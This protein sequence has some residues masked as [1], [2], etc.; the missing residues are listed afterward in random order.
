MYDNIVNYQAAYEA[1]EKDGSQKAYVY[2]TDI[3]GKDLDPFYSYSKK[4]DITGETSYYVVGPQVSDVFYNVDRATK[5]VVTT[6]TDKA[7]ISKKVATLLDEEGKDVVDENGAPVQYVKY[8]AL[9]I[10]TAENYKKY[11]LD[12]DDDDDTSSGLTSAQKTVFSTYYVTAIEQ[13]FDASEA[14][15]TE[16]AALAKDAKFSLNANISKDALI[17]TLEEALAE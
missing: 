16:Q 10:L 17:A 14:I 13:L 2:G 8:E 15:V 4:N 9:E 11:L 3:T 1:Y 5:L 12:S 7:K 6:A